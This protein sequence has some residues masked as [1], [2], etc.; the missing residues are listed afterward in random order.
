MKREKQKCAKLLPEVKGLRE[1]LQQD[2][3]ER[4]EFGAQAVSFKAN[5]EELKT[6]HTHDREEL[7]SK[8]GIDLAATY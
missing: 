2:Q 5:V 3:A 8:A 6:Q 4:D 7:N 1:R